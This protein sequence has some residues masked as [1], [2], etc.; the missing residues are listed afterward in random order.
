M[1][2]HLKIS[3]T[4]REYKKCT[5]DT[6]KDNIKDFIQANIENT[7][8]NLNKVLDLVDILQENFAKESKI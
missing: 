6:D 2:N 1:K 7:K 4:T 8:F 3:K 5:N